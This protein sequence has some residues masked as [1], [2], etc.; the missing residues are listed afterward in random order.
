MKM[1]EEILEMYHEEKAEAR[2]CGDFD[3][4]TFRDW[5]QNMSDPQAERVRAEIAL[6]FCEDQELQHPNTSDKGVFQ[7]DN[8]ITKGNRNG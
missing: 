8:A 6:E 7:C 5:L 3:F 2:A 1:D 4:P